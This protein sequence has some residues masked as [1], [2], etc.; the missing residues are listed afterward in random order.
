MKLVVDM[1]LSPDRVAYLKE[2]GHDAIHWSSV[3]AANAPDDDILR[4]ATDQERIVLTG[5]LDFGALLALSGSSKPSVVQLRSGATLPSRVGPFVGRALRYA[6]ADL[7][8]GAIVTVE[9]DRLRL[10]LLNFAVKE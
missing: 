3:G 1:N 5:D 10:R 2:A 8:T 6:E 9:D 4:W 7:S